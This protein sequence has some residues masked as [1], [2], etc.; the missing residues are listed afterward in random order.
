VDQQSF[1]GALV[2]DYRRG[3]E[4]KGG[5]ETLLQRL[6]H[7]SDKCEGYPTRNFLIQKDRPSDD[8]LCSRCERV[9]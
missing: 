5:G 2:R 8:D 9:R 4:C 7:F 1:P 6:W 3:I